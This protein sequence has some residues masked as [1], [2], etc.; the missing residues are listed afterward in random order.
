MSR[1][2]ELTDEEFDL[3]CMA[4]DTAVSTLAEADS[5]HDEDQMIDNKYYL[6][7]KDLQKIFPE[8]GPYELNEDVG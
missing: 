5:E 6:L 7:Y 1:Y 4:V 8:P 2:V 3:V